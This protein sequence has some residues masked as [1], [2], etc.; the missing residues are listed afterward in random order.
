MGYQSMDGLHRIIP[1]IPSSNPPET[2][3]FMVEVLGF[4]V[5]TELDF[6]TELSAGGHC[7]GVLFSDGEPNPQSVYLHIDDVDALWANQQA[8]LE[9]AQPRAPFN[10]SYGM[11]ELHLIVPATRTLL[12]I[13][14]PLQPNPEAP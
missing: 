2:V 14:S 1:H 3:R 7:F 5:T 4:G 8:Q 10:Q 12:M 11:R 6:Y 9:P 13:G